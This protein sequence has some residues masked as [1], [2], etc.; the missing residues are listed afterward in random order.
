MPLR[1]TLGAFIASLQRP[2]QRAL[3]DD[4]VG[5]FTGESALCSSSSSTTPHS[6]NRK[7]LSTQLFCSPRRS[8]SSMC[9][10]VCND[11][12]G[13]G[14]PSRQKRLNSRNKTVFELDNGA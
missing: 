5:H 12:D 1:Q 11:D 7:N 13:S 14:A 10:Y 4:L 3:A 6:W 8:L 2:I 9:D